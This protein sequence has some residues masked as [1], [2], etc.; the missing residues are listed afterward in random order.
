MS[1][2]RSSRRSA[3]PRPP[4]R[5]SPSASSNRSGRPRTIPCCSPFP[6]R[7][8]SPACSSSESDGPTRRESFP[9]VRGFAILGASMTE[10]VAGPPSG[11][12]PAPPPRRRGSRR[13][14]RVIALVAAVAVLAGGLAFARWLVYRLNHSITGDAFVESDMINLAP[15]VPGEIVDMLVQDNQRV[16]RGELLCRIDPTIFLRDVETAT[17]NLEVADAE[18]HGATAA[19]TSLGQRVPEQIAR[20]ERELAAARNERGAAEQALARTRETVAHEIARAE[21]DLA[22]ARANLEFADITLKR[23]DALVEGR[24]VGKEERDA[25]RA[26]YATNLALHEDAKVK[27]AQAVTNRKQIEI[28][29]Q[30]LAAAVNKVRQATATVEI[31]RVG[32]VDV[33]EARR[34]V[35]VARQKIELARRELARRQSFLAYTDVVSPFDGVVVKRFRFKGDYATPGTAIFIMYES[36]NI[37]VTANMPETELEGLGPGHRVL[38]KVDAF[39]EPFEGKVLWIYASTGA[40]FSLIPRNVSSGEFIRVVQRVP[41]RILVDERDP[42]WPELRPGLSATVYVSHDQAG[43]RSELAIPP[44]IPPR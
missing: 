11:E 2:P 30:T 17:A 37:Y 26:A 41:I 6:R 29:E 32:L 27:L 22:A 40:K 24:A 12:P 16:A 23:Y 25:K 14:R 33:D 21:H 9:L 7:A 34:R 20:A 10:S 15:Q 35:D 39:K 44:A 13:G 1:R 38:V 4:T 3:A 43:A 19:L 8:T 42:R 28:A 31:A 36:R 5:A 18:R